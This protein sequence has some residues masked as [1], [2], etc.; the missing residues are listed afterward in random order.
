[1][2]YMMAKSLNTS[3]PLIH[4]YLYGNLLACG[5]VMR[6]DQWEIISACEDDIEITCKKCLAYNAAQRRGGGEA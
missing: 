1:M 3:R 2:Q 4:I 6:G 5:K